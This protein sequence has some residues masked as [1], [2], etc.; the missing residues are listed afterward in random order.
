MA[1]ED[2]DKKPVVTKEEPQ[3]SPPDDKPEPKEEKPSEPP[4]EEP[5]EPKEEKEQEPEAAVEAPPATEEEEPTPEEEPEQKKPS[6]RESLRIQ[7][8]ISKFKQQSPQQPSPPEGLDYEKELDADPE[9]INKLKADR[10]SAAQSSYTQGLDQAKY[11][12]WDT[13]LKMDAPNVESKY[14]FLNPRDKENF[15]KVRADA[16]NSLYLQA[17]GY[18]DGDP[19]K[20]IAPSVQNPNIRYADFVEAQME[21]AEALMAEQQQRSAKNI[22]TQAANTGLRPDGGSAKPLDLSKHPK[23][24]TDAE[25]KAA[26]ESDPNL[27]K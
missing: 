25:L 16:M 9:V 21:F 7:Q 12:Q 22:A 1:D 18:D 24:M 20:G 10:D 4:K 27:R 23:D 8:L 6:R 2:D 26:V 19:D 17:T 5:K 13:L 14:K 3:E 15:D 11:L